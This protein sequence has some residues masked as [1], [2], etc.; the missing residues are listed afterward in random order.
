[1]TGSN[2][3]M[4]GKPVTERNI[5]YLGLILAIVM[6]YFILLLSVVLVYACNGNIGK[7]NLFSCS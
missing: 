5:L 1:M 3:P 2:N 7:L 4:F 6:Y